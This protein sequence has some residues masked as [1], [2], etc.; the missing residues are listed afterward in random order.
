MSHHKNYSS[1]ISV[2]TDFG[3]RDP[4]VGAVKGVIFSI[5]PGA[6]VV[7]I[8]HEVEAGNVFQGAYLLANSYPFFPAGTVHLAVVDPGVGGKRKP[9]MVETDSYFF[10]GP[11]NG[12]FSYIFE[13][14]KNIRCF[15]LKNREYFLG[16]ISGTFHARDIFAPV[17]A[18]LSMGVSPEEFGPPIGEFKKLTD[19][20]CQS[21][22]ESVKGKVVHVDR[23]GNVITNIPVDL[24]DC[25]TPS[26]NLK[27]ITLKGLKRSYSEVR[28]GEPLLI[29]GSGGC[30]EISLREGNASRFFNLKPGDSILIEKSA[31]PSYGGSAHFE[32]TGKK[33]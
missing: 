30:L 22:R 12:I 23:F 5:N 25:S 4:Y 33:E 3:L 19:I 10:V 17:A 32:Q 27:G 31:S 13:K 9:I 21:D 11:D 29:Q 26:L 1:I 7:D 15:E 2:L 6:R 18:Y 24:L 20:H 14:E 28:K 16:H 8:S